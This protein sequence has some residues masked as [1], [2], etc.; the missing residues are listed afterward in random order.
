MG[1]LL[2]EYATSKLPQAEMVNNVISQGKILKEELT[3]EILKN[4]LKSQNLTDGILLDGYPRGMISVSLLKEFLK[5]DK[6]VVVNADFELIKTRVLNRLTCSKCKKVFSKLNYDKNQCDE[7]SGDLI[8]RKDDNLDS[9]QTRMN[10]YQT[11]T[12]PVIDYYKKQGI[13]FEVDSNNEITK[14]LDELMEKI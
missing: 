2:R 9:L 8:I 4:Y 1:D 7:C 5:V 10:E 11:L 6:V 3:T 12:M 14:Q 13:V